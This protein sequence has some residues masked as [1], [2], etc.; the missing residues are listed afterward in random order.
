VKIGLVARSEHRGLGVMSKDFYDNMHPDKTLVVVP[1]GVRHAGLTSHFEWFP[2]ATHVG[3]DGSLHRRTVCEFLDGL[4]VVYSAETYYDWR[5]CTYARDLGVATVCHAMPEWYRSLWAHG[6]HPPT[7][8]WVP[9]SWRL[10]GMPEGTKVVP[11]PIALDRLRE[12]DDEPVH[13]EPFR[14]VHV[15]GATTYADRNG[16]RAVLRAAQLISGDQQVTV[17][18]QI[19]DDIPPVE[20]ERLHVDGEHVEDS[21]D[22]YRDADAF[23]MPRRYAGLCLPVLEAFGS[24]LPVIMTDLSP[25]N[26]DWPV[27]VVRT[28]PNGSVQ[29]MGNTIPTPSVDIEHLVATMN[30][31]ASDPDEVARWRTSARTYA[32]NMSWEKRAPVI[33]E[34]LAKVIG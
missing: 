21:A 8:W 7:A 14:W 26:T 22:L 34:E 31:W 6:P 32:I 4:D 13:T 5:F 10:E 28:K 1:E 27:E 30:R 3:Y 24:G 16:T 29:I 9:T 20:C 11:V 18:T 19:P 33:R 23:L 17:R 15:A 25:Q 12:W 2:D